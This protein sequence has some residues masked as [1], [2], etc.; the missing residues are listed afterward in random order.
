MNLAP[1]GGEFKRDVGSK[2][3]LV[4]LNWEQIERLISCTN[5]SYPPEWKCKSEDHVCLKERKRKFPK[6]RAPTH[7]DDLLRRMKRLNGTTLWYFKS[8][9]RNYDAIKR[10]LGILKP[11]YNINIDFAYS[12]ISLMTP[13]KKA[14]KVGFPSSGLAIYSAATQFCKQITMFGFYPFSQDWR[15]RT[16]RHHYY[17]EGTMNYTSNQ[18]H[19]PNEYRIL[20]ELNRTGAINLVNECR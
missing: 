12:P 15:N 16:L 9:G 5:S 1:P 13:S 7:C 8:I 11:K 17:E 2:V 19:M 14:W 6:P 4:S 20:L 18:H 10:M 3:N